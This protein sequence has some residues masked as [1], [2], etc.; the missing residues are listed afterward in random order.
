MGMNQIPPQDKEVVID[1]LA[2]GES[3]SQAMVGTAIRSKDT[4][5]RIARQESNTIE[6]KRQQYLK[7]IKKLGANDIK[8]AEM[9]VKMMYATKKIGKEVVEAPDWQARATALKYIDSL[10]DLN[11]TNEM[12]LDFTDH[13]PQPLQEISEAEKLDFN[14]KFRKFI[15]L[16][17]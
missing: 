9:W 2:Q 17:N 1:R 12:K 16:Q 15:K 11:N 13:T 6:Q 4:V 8:R 14:E 7:N 3:Y 5:H 10:G